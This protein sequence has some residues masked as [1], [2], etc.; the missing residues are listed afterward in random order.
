MFRQ[1]RNVKTVDIGLN[2]YTQAI[3]LWVSVGPGIL[4]EP[5]GANYLSSISV[6]IWKFR[7]LQADIF[8]SAF[9]AF[10]YLKAEFSIAQYSIFYLVDI[11]AVLEERKATRYIK[12]KL[13][14][15]R[16]EM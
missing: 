11:W 4:W 14:R 7:I 5:T 13:P 3:V 16:I 1:W 6:I 9:F 12:Q 2:I 15:C 10:A 8:G